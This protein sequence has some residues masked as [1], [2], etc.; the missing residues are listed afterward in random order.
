MGQITAHLLAC[1]EL[2]L[3][4]ALY[5]EDP[6]IA[7]R[8]EGEVVDAMKCQTV[9]SVALSVRHATLLQTKQDPGNMSGSMWQDYV[10]WPMSVNGQKWAT[11]MKPPVLAPSQSITLRT[12]SSWFS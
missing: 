9:L 7:C 6:M 3:E 1:G 8:T 11:V 5:R 4:A 10:D 2:E 12:Q